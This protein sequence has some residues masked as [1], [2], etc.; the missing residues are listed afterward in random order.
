[1]DKYYAEHKDVYKWGERV[2]ALVVSSKEKDKVEA[3]YKFAQDFSTGKIKPDMIWKKVCNDTTEAC[4]NCQ[5]TLFEKQDNHIIDSLGWEPGITPIV[6]G[7]GKYGFFVKKGIQPA[8]P[9]TYDE[10][11][12]T[13]IA[14]YQVLLEKNYLDELKK[15][16]K[17][18][19]DE[20]VLES[21]KK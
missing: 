7:E 16:Y 20:K 9:K 18:V 11:K 15:K 14:D 3:A 10:A 4:F 17:V 21:L 1:L 19:V 6:F 8:R 5:V 2:E 13:V 12:G